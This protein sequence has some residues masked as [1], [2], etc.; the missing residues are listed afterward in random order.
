M[1]DQEKQILEEIADHYTHGSLLDAVKAGVETLGRTTDTIHVDELAPLDEFHIGGRIAS[2]DFLGMLG[3]GDG[4]HVLDVGCGLGGPARFSAHRF[5]CTVTGIDLTPEFTETGNHMSSWVGLNDRVS[6]HT[7]SA[8]ETPFEDNSFDAAYMMHVG[9]NIADKGT[10]FSE[11][12]RVL[13]PGATFG[14][15]DVM[16]IGDST[17]TYPVPWA[18]TARTSALAS[19]D[20]YKSHLQDAGF[21]I[22]HERSRRDFALDFF[23]D[24]SAK[25]AAA[26]GPPPLGLHILMGESRVEKVKNMVSNISANV[27]AP[28]E[29][30]AH[31]AV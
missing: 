2:E 23:A 14:V 11:V 1:S 18:E 15:Y 9:M 10:L 6:L 7:G 27:I 21:S 12:H 26:E 28:V 31:K 22:S 19:P 24:L 30:I 25:A 20:V 5:G 3:L 16:Q 17:M 29:L 13:K 8:L 4:V